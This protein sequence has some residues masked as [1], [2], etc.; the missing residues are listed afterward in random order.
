[1]AELPEIPNL[2]L[3]APTANHQVPAEAVAKKPPAPTAAK[4][5]AKPAAKAPAE[6]VA[7]PA[8]DVPMEIK[9][10]EPLDEVLQQSTELAVHLAH[11]EELINGISSQH[12][13][14]QDEMHAGFAEMRAV[15]GST[16]E[17][18]KKDKVAGA[19]QELWRQAMAERLD[20]VEENGRRVVSRATVGLMLA[21]V[22]SLLIVGLVA[23]LL[24]G[25]GH[26]GAGSSPDTGASYLNAPAKTDSVSSIPGTRA[27]E[28]APAPPAD[29]LK[30]A[31]KKKKK[32]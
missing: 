29:L 19:E 14:L 22:Q 10:P 20:L 7:S 9:E 30:G 8:P 23:F 1:M 27:P 25:P 4:A 26:P 5:P 15:A 13:D 31:P 11:L 2:D 3:G 21:V 28:D 24:K 32:H 6:A 12:N 18:D 17:I 16:T